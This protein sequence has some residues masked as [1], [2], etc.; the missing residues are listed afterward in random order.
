MVLFVFGNGDFLFFLGCFFLIIIG[1]INV[2]SKVKKE[3]RNRYICFIVVLKVIFRDVV[4]DGL[5]YF[6]KFKIFVIDGIFDIL[7]GIR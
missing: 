5:L 7:F 4:F 6:G 3:N 1:V 2:I